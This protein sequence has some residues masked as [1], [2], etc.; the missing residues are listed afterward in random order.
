MII[1]SR[2]LYGHQSF[3]KANFSFKMRYC[4]YNSS[5]NLEWS[6]EKYL[7]L[8]KYDR[9]LLGVDVRINENS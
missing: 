4:N 8:R 1:Q 3:K 7:E 2:Y 9:N 5:I 6:Y